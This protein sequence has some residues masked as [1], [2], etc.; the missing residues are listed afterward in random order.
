[1][2]LPVSEDDLANYVA[3]LHQKGYAPST[4]T[5]TLS[6]IS[7][8]HKLNNV[9]DPTEAFLIKKMLAGCRNL[10]SKKDDRVPMTLEVLHAVIQRADVYFSG[11]ADSIRFKAMCALAF[12]ALLRVGEMTSSPNNIQKEDITVLDDRIHICFRRC[13]HSNGETSRHEILKREDP[14]ICPV[15]NVTSF[16]QIRKQGPGPL[17]SHTSGKSVKR[18]EFASELKGILMSLGLGNT[19]YTSHS[20]RIGAASWL[21]ATG[22]SDLQIQR[23]GRWKSQAFQNYI[24]L[25]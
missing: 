15:R 8:I 21:A 20:F 10:R 4:I 25:N 14:V 2:S 19:R 9:A 16:L 11:Q 24:R 3:Y 17:F 13:K 5:S 7:Y 23:A 6:A 22:H 18:D 12:F 1:M